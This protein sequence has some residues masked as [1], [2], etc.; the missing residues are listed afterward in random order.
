MIHRTLI[1]GRWVAD[2]LFATEGYDI[3]GVLGC[4]WDAHAPRHIISQAERLMLS[5]SRNCGFTYSNPHYRRAVV[6]IGPT[7]SG[8]E[9]LNTFVHEVR[10]LADGI[11]KSLGVDLDSESPAYLAGETARALADTVCMLGCQ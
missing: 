10:H 5:C 6:L 9:F 3:E 8:A 2:F 4:L 7:T 11:A 1:I